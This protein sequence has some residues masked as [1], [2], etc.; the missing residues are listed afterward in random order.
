MF[1]LALLLWL[2]V[3]R[4]ARSVWKRT[5]GR[6]GQRVVAVVTAAAILAALAWAW[7][8]DDDRYRPIT[9]NERGTITDLVSQD[10]P[11]PSEPPTA[12]EPPGPDYVNRAEI[13]WPAGV[14]QP[15]RRD[16]TLALVMVPR[17]PG[18]SGNLTEPSP[19][20]NT[21]PSAP[22]PTATTPSVPVPTATTP[23]DPPGSDDPQSPTAPVWV[24]PFDEPLPPEPGDNQAFAVNTTDNTVVYDI[25]F[26]LIWVEDSADPVTNTNEA[27]AYASCTRCAAVAI[28]FQVVLVVGDADVVVPQNLAG[29]LNYNCVQC[30]TYAL[31]TQLVVTL[32]S[33]LSADGMAALNQLW[34]QLAEFAQSIEDYPLSELRDQLTS[35]EQQILDVIAADAG[36]TLPGA[37]TPTSPAPPE[38]GSTSGESPTTPASQNEPTPVAPTA[39]P[40]PSP[41]TASQSPEPTPTTSQPSPT[42]EPSPTE[43][44]PTPTPTTSPTPTEPTTT[45]ETP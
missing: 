6:P 28:G 31:A 12:T 22:A 20:T 21:T 16:P 18:D 30:L 24:F 32:D 35:Y 15:T 8:P 3:G 11:A 2:L 27:Y 39:T 36:L 17:T 38:E 42:D 40:T 14:E 5:T 43:P 10:E 45:T 4:V 9:P 25:A 13:V 23:S 7:W 26:A 29:A 41:P 19:S 37:P 1:G 44:Q 34:A 33:P